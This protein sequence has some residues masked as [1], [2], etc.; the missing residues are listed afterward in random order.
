MPSS[1]RRYVEVDTPGT[2]RYSQRAGCTC[3]SLLSVLGLVPFPTAGLHFIIGRTQLGRAGLAGGGR[4]QAF[5]DSALGGRDLFTQLCDD[6]FLGGL[7]RS[8]ERRVGKEW[9]PAGIPPS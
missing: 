7:D 5:D 1:S 6:A 2:R 8:E 3:G 9:R 4:L